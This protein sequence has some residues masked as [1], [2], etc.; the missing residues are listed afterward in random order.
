LADAS[1]P[2]GCYATAHLHGGERFQ[3]RDK[4]PRKTPIVGH[5][6]I[7]HKIQL[8]QQFSHQSQGGPLVSLALHENIE[9]FA[10]GVDGAPQIDQTPIDFDVHLVKMPCGMR[11]G[12]A[13]AEI[14][15]N[16]GAKMVHPATHRFIRNRDPAFGQQV[17]DIAEVQG[18]AG[19]KPDGLLMITGG[20]DTRCS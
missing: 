19:R 14:G 3:D 18:E 15:C 4:L 11:P 20:T 9:D 10:L 7:R 8:L 5:Q 13:F 17:L 1:F 2:L 12:A 16:R 6:L